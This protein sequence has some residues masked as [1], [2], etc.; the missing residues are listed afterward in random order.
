MV[1]GIFFAT[2]FPVLALGLSACAA[3]A[4]VFLNSHYGAADVHRVAIID[5]QDYPGMA[6]SGRLVQRIFEKYLFEN[7]YNMVDSRQVAAVMEQLSIQPGD[8]LNPDTMRVLA[9]KLGVDAFVF[10]EVTDFTDASSQTVVEDMMLE[11]DTPIYTNVN[12]YQRVPGG[13]MV[14]TSQ[15]IQTGTEISTVDQPVKQTEVVDAHVGLSVRMVDART[16]EVLW[17][18]SDSED[19][20]HL[21][22]ASE[23]A[24]A[25][26]SKALHASIKKL[27][28]K[29]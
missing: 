14:A 27:G 5:F 26:I 15:S 1:R 28:S 11:Q 25:Q 10:G 8:N 16:G 6:G 12:T 2:V 22:D 9:L 20:S 7:G 23:S 13:G 18:A 3:P 21:N 29:A 19:G 17:S 24:S 4:L